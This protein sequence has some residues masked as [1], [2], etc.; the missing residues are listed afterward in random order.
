MKIALIS[1]LLAISQSSLAQVPITHRL[2]VQGDTLRYKVEAF[3]LTDVLHFSTMDSVQNF[4]SP[5]KYEGKR[6]SFVLATGDQQITVGHRNGKVLT[7]R[8]AL[9]SGSLTKYIQ[10]RF[11]GDISA[12]FSADYQQQ[13][14]GKV[15]CEIPETFE[16]ANIA[17]ALTEVGQK[18]PNMIE[19]SGDYFSRVQHYFAP[20]TKHPLILRLNQQLKTGGNNFYNGVRQNAYIMALNPQGM[21]TQVGIY[22]AMWPGVNDMAEHADQW[23]DFV[24]QSGFRQFYQAN[25]PFY[26]QDIATVRRLLPVKQMQTWLESQ[27]PGIVYNGQKVIF[28]PL[29]SGD[30][31]TQKFTD[32]DYQECLMFICDAKGYDHK[33]YSDAQIEGLYSG[34]VFTEIDH[35][36]VNPTSDKHLTAIN[37]AFNDRQKWTRKG[38]SDHYG[39][40]YDV[41]NE[42]MTHSLHLLYINDRYSADVYQLVR[43]DR[44]KLNA[45]QRGFYRIEAFLNELQRLYK[46]KGPTQTVADLYIPLLAWAK[47]VE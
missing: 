4:N 26:Q 17:M 39:S 30:H 27:F 32:Q 31:A 45:D 36:F 21:P 22:A 6:I 33:T 35:N 47:R 18:D 25:Q 46:A 2:Q 8:I 19:Q 3:K 15:T 24:Q 1:S 37:E 14:Q 11:L 38:D 9:T 10:I 41:F 44:I 20:V 28:S 23:A 13:F 40:A 42:Y 43:A 12:H 16:L 34:I 7:Q 5:Q 29:I